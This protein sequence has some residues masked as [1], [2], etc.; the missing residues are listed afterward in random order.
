[1]HKKTYVI[2]IDNETRRALE[3]RQDK[4]KALIKKVTGKEKKIPLT[5]V[6]KISVKNP[7]RLNYFEAIDLER[8]LKKK[9]SKL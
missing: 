6:L 3:T 9:G 4:F 1:M 2:K 8:K 7:I 5:K